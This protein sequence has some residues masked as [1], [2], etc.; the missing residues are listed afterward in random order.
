[1]TVVPSDE[2]LTDDHRAAE[3]D[4]GA[5]N[6][7]DEAETEGFTLPESNSYRVVAVVQ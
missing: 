1:V 2:E 5:R 7:L 4:A 6:G 3:R